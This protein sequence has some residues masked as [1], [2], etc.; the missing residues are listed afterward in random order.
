MNTKT[1]ITDGTDYQGIQIHCELKSIPDS[2]NLD[3]TEIIQRAVDEHDLN[4]RQDSFGFNHFQRIH[5]WLVK[6]YSV[7]QSDPQDISTLSDC[8]IDEEF[9]DN[10]IE[11]MKEDLPWLFPV[12]E[13]SGGDNGKVYLDEEDY[14]TDLNTKLQYIKERQV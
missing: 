8:G 13:E 9:I 3:F 2:I 6:N 10:L 11:N 12:E 1:N 14:K 4:V 7:Y 5:R